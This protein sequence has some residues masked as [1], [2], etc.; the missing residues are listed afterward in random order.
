MS[1]T[2]EMMLAIK[3]RNICV[4]Y[5]K[6]TD[7]FDTYPVSAIQL[8]T[9]DPNARIP[10]KDENNF[11]FL[12]YEEINHKDIM[13][14]YVKECVEDK[15]IRK[16]LFSILRRKDY[17]DPFVEELKKLNLYDDFDMVCGD[18]YEQI[19]SNWAEKNDLHF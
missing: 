11:R 14:F 4:F 7:T 19:F 9:L 15:A 17:V 1:S 2:M 12:T 10:L 18:I 8:Q 13:S 5:H 16:Q 6:D 3:N